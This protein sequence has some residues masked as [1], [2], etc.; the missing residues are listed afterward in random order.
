MTDGFEAEGNLRDDTPK[1]KF[2]NGE[3]VVIIKDIKHEYQ[4]K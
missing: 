4:S 2:V 3:I 1:C